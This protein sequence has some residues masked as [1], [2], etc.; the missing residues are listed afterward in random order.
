MDSHC[1]SCGRGTQ[2]GG[3]KQYIST[4]ATGPWRVRRDFEIQKIQGINQGGPILKNLITE[5]SFHSVD[6]VP[7]GSLIICKLTDDDSD[8]V[9]EGKI[10]TLA[11]TLASSTVTFIPIT[12]LAF[13][14]AN[15][16]QNI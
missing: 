14:G 3:S 8:V 10:G 12:N 5:C 1:W 15:D 4:R 2:D 6:P 16:V 9:A 13:I 11:H 7:K